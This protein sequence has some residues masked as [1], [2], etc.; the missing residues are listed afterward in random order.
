MPYRVDKYKDITRIVGISTDELNLDKTL[1]CGQAFRWNKTQNDSWYGTIGQKLVILR[2]G[3]FIDG[4]YGIATNL[5]V[6]DVKELIYYL[7]L[8]T[9]YTSEVS[10]LDLDIYAKKAYGHGKGIHILRQDLFETMV[11][12]LMS[13]CNSMHNIKLI[14]DKLSEKYGN[15]VHEKWFTEDIE[16]Y[17]FPTLEKLGECSYDDFMK[18]SI[19]FRSKYLVSMLNSIKDN[20]SV[21]NYLKNC[22]YDNAMNILTSYDGI[23]EKV[24]N[25]ISLFGLHHVEAFPIDTHIRKIIQ[26]E[27]NGNIDI[28][29]YGQIAGIIQ[30]YMYYYSAFKMEG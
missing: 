15:K 25:C 5:D 8:D 23:G 22:N 11:T 6:C 10:K 26:S 20:Y 7:D 12:F 19:G 16:Y 9:D 27:Y 24:A 21:L 4:E 18:C 28:A 17:T 30:Q 29:R 3:R 13:Q 1:R 14:V 2:Q